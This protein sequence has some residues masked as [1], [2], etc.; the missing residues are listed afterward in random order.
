MAGSEE[1]DLSSLAQK[2]DELYRASGKVDYV[3]PKLSHE[4]ARELPHAWEEPAA[5]KKPKRPRR[6]TYAAMFLG[7]SVLFFLVAGA[8]A[9]YML[10]SGGNSVSANKIDVVIQGPTTIAGGDTVPLSLA[11][12]NRNPTALKDATIEIDFP[13]GTRSATDV[14][15]DYP[16]YV[17]NLGT[18]MPGQTVT[19][20]IKAVVFGAA[21]QT[22]TLPVMLSYGTANSNSTFQK[23]SSYAIAVSS[24]PLS[25][26]VQ[27]LSETVSGKPLTF[28]ID[29]RSNA[30]VALSDVALHA[31][32][33]F[34]FSVASSSLPIDSGNTMY[35]GSL[36][37]GASKKIT[38]TGALIG[39]D[40]EQRVFHFTIGTVPN[41]QTAALG[42]TYMTQDVAVTIAA[43]FISTTLA[44]NNNA[45]GANVLTPGTTENVTLRYTNT[46]ATTITNATIQIA[47]SGAAIDYGSVSAAG[48]FYDSSNHALVFS[49][50]TDSAL[51]SLAPGATGSETFSFAVPPNLTTSPTANFSIS[52]SGTR[53]GQSNVPEQ[54]SASTE[55][56]AKAV[57]QVAL[58]SIASH[59]MGGVALPG[60]IPPQANQQ[61]TYAITLTAHNGS[62]AL[63]GGTITTTLPNYV[64]YTGNTSGTGTVSYDGASRTITWD[65]GDMTPA[66]NAQ[67]TFEVV[68]TPSTSQRGSAVT[69]T[70]PFSLTGFDRFAQININVSAPAVTTAIS[71]D[72]GY[73][74]SESL[75]Q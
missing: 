59:R 66:E 51:K 26:S 9:A 24:T 49:A 35:L 29:V 64:N 10:Y 15:Q 33:P 42:V 2:R 5:P 30:S 48:G 31:A 56:S 18:L 72:P 41:A 16:R 6:F 38:L 67:A 69:L 22:L 45:S 20:S 61:T 62:N 40:K 14:S 17:D 13:A 23:K 71:G 50:T 53:I 68:L 74:T 11:I 4:H 73:S 70:T 65:V 7:F 34:G 54:V 46:L 55:T 58:S 36:S 47:L 21:G 12:T 1:S 39:Q 44:F 19:R 75:V 57:T 3:R 8:L 43:P 63:A 28:T 52:V 25:V 32:L 60:P 27:T 37:P